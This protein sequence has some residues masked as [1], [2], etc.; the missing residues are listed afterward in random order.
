[1]RFTAVFHDPDGRITSVQRNATANVIGGRSY[2]EADFDGDPD[3]FYVSGGEVISK[4]EKPS[5]AHVFDYSS[6]SW[7]LDLSEAKDQA[8][9]QIK[10]DREDQEYGAFTWNSHT[11]QCDQL[12]QS[13]IMSAVQRAQLDSTLTMVWTLSDN[14]TVS[15]NATELKQ[16][17]QALSA[18]IDACHIKARGLR[19]QIDA[20]TTEVDLDAITW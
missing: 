19:S 20:A 16:V 6:A 18:H 1:M 3:D 4:G 5:S 15:L 9:E 11:F 13:R 14:T 17:G 7:T 8:W 10:Q 2:V 12:S